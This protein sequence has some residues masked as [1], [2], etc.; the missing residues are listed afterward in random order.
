MKNQGS[1]MNK[2]KLIAL[3]AALALPASAHAVTLY[4]DS[5]A[6]VVLEG[7]LHVSV[8]LIDIGDAPA[9]GA[10]DGSDFTINNH[11]SELVLAGSHEISPGLDGIWEL[12][13]NVATTGEGGTDVFL[14]SRDSYIGVQGGFGMLRVGILDTA[15][16]DADDELEDDNPGNSAF[17]IDP[18][19][20]N[21]S[22]WKAIMHSLPGDGGSD[23]FFDTRARD[24][25]EYASPRAGG[26]NFRVAFHGD[27]READANDAGLEI[28]KDDNDIAGYSAS[29]SG[30]WGDFGA[31]GAVEVQNFDG[32]DRTFGPGTATGIDSPSAFNLGLQ[33]GNA[34]GWRLGGVVETIDVDDAAGDFARDA[35]YLMGAKEY[36]ANLA[37]AKVASADE[38]DGFADT[39]ADF[40]AVGFQRDVNSR[41]QIYI[42][43][44]Q[45]SNEDNATY[46][47]DSGGTGIGVAAPGEDVSGI[48]FGTIYAF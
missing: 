33:W 31:F 32:G 25:I 21:I 23:D 8:G 39:G 48:V 29:V 10:D 22:D 26:V 7:E 6:S 16:E 3:A 2:E 46:S 9:P 35:F 5:Q 17:A 36:G 37:Y 13:T 47:F 43:A 11:F 19:P 30:A 1:T 12:A 42:E 14:G 4:E 24:S 45:T 28:G 18:R 34:A 27:S 44:A 40:V 20:D 41:T 15:F 38:L